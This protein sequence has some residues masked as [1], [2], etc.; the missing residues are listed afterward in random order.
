[1]SFVSDMLINEGVLFR[2]ST[3]RYLGGYIKLNKFIRPKLKFIHI[4]EDEMNIFCKEFIGNLGYPNLIIDNTKPKFTE[5]TYIRSDSFDGLIT[6][7]KLRMSINSNLI[8]RQ[9]Y[10]TEYPQGYYYV[11]VRAFNDL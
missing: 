4:S 1:M 11:I 7:I 3:I 5:Y 6:S 8:I 2:E 10:K 9:I